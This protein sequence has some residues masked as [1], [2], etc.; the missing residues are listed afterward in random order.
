MADA[1]AVTV[2]LWLGVRVCVTEGVP[3]VLPVLV[4]LRVPEGVPVALAVIEPLEVIVDVASCV[5]EGL[6]EAVRD[7]E[8]VP[9]GV[10]VA[11]DNWLP[12]GE[13]VDDWVAV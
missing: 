10:E 11:V 8:A 4:T 13:N 2:G 6:S 7:C 1:V 12:L 5:R 3:V 9:D